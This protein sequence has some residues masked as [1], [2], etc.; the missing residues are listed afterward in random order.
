MWVREG[1]Q[2]GGELR[3]HARAHKIPVPS[4]IKIQLRPWSRS[5][6][7]ILAPH[8]PRREITSTWRAPPA[9]LRVATIQQYHAFGFRAE[10]V[11][12][13]R[14]PDGSNLWEMQEICALARRVISRGLVCVTGLATIPS[15]RG[16]LVSTTAADGPRADAVSPLTATHTRDC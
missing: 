7:L 5:N 14:H 16:R 2:A 13:T 8:L 12:Q 3:A 6:S 10:R 9:S 1:G 15:V 4:D 11:Y